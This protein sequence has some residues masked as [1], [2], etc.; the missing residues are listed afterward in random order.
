MTTPR[1][2]TE[3]AASDEPDL[4][5]LLAA[6]PDVAEILDDVRIAYGLKENHV[7][8]IDYP[9][10]LATRELLLSAGRRLQAQGTLDDPDD[11]WLLRRSELRALILDDSAL[12]VPATSRKSAASSTSP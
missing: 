4:A 7:Y 2:R 9:G 11:L 1:G 3:P 10:L 8:H 6:A 12:D 5:A